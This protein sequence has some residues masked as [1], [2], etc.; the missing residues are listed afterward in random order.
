MSE[1]LNKKR[2]IRFRKGIILDGDGILKMSFYFAEHR[3][4]LRKCMMTCLLVE[5]R[6]DLAVIVC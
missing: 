1:T 5:I 6:F 4:I 3:I 2:K